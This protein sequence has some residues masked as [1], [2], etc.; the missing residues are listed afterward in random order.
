LWGLAAIGGF[1]LSGSGTGGWP[2]RRRPGTDENFKKVLHGE[3][4]THGRQ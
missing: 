1:P 3:R 4:E 2:G